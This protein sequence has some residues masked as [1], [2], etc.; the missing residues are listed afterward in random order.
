MFEKILLPLDG[1][2][3]AEE[4]IP[5]GEELAAKLGSELILFHVCDDSHQLSHSM[6]RHYIERL[7]ETSQERLGSKASASAVQLFGDFAQAI[8]DYCASNDIGLVIMVA[9]GF[10]SFKV[11]I[12]GS[13]VDRVFRLISCPSLLVQTGDSRRKG[14]RNGLIHR[15][16]LP[17]D[18]SEHSELAVPY[19]RQLGIKLGA[20]VVLFTMARRSH[21]LTSKDD[22]IG[23]A[24]MNDEIVNA[25][26]A[27]R[28][29]SYLSG[30]AKSMARE[31][32]KV[33]TRVSLG[34]DQGSA[35]TQACQEAAADL[36][37]MATSGRQPITAWAPGSI[38]HKLL[39]K[40]DLPLL[41]VG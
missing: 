34:D 19:A 41:I 8:S 35:I 23:E 5:Y 11:M 36:V 20:E 27:K 39:N 16:L 12:M 17:L 40:G 15:I 37:L 26:E 21:M 25:A 32:L 1:S 31:G 22:I 10:T 28:C 7:A 33:A 29:R 38:A 13:I 3:L 14:A 24:G 18:G 4:V 2:D 6:H 30:V 9:H